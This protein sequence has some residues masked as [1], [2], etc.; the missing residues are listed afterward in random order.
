M[1]NRC[2]ILK[3]LSFKNPLLDGGGQFSYSVDDGAFGGGKNDAKFVITCGRVFEAGVYEGAKFWREGVE[4]RAFFNLAEERDLLLRGVDL[5][6][7]VRRVAIRAPIGHVFYLAHR[8]LVVEFTDTLDRADVCQEVTDALAVLYIHPIVRDVRE[9]IVDGKAF[10]QV[11]CRDHVWGEEL[12]MIR[13]F[14]TST[15]GQDKVADGV[16]LG[17]NR[18]LV[19]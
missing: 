4:C 2:F 6:F 8:D 5:L 11:M 1:G 14:E 13:G 10:T 9:D 16:N 18:F 17:V 7:N 19:F 3:S 12:E 15:C